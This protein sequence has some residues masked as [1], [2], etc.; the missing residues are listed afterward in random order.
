MAASGGSAKF[1]R[2]PSIQQLQLFLILS[3]ELH[4]GRAARRAYMAQPTFSRHITT[5][6]ERLGVNLVDRTTRRVALSAAGETLVARARSVVEAADGLCR[7][8]ATRANAAAG[9][10]VIGSFEAMTSVDPIPAVLDELRRTRP[11]LDVEVLRIGFDAAT[12]ILRGEVDAAFVALPVPD[13]I[14]TL[15]LTGGPRCAAMSS[16]NALADRGPLTLADLARKPHIGW[17]ERVPKVYRDFWAVDPR[18]DGEPVRYTPHA[19]VDYESALPLIAMGEGIQLPP[20]AARWLYPRPGVSYVEVTGLQP[21]TAA[22]AWL[23]GKRDEPFVAALR[24]AT[25]EVLR[26]GRG[27]LMYREGLSGGSGRISAAPH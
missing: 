16:D 7:E 11:R 12:A 21:W 17:S 25:R 13:G 6:E 27:W 9:R 10:M 19:V 26:R 8:A 18:P 22:L 20:D 4:F 2:Y 1:A 3:E 24:E 23:P 14:Q 15:P 5:L